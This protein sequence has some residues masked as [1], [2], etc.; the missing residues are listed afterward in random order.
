M[1]RSTA[2]KAMT[3]PYPASAE[4]LRD[5]IE[6]HFLALA[7]L[8]ILELGLAG[9]HSLRSDDHLPGCADQVHVGELGAGPEIAVVV[10]SL[11][12]LGSEAVT[13]FLAGAGHGAV[14]RLQVDDGDF[15]RR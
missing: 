3:S 6:R 1:R 15:E 4:P 7:G 8:A 12:A 13:E 14:V 10:Q 5:L 11:D 9:R 2:A